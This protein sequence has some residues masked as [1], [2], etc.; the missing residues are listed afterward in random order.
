MNMSSYG[1]PKKCSVKLHK[2]GSCVLAVM[3]DS[4]VKTGFI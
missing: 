4:T 1:P 2:T 3:K